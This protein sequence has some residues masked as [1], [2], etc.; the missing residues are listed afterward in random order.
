[1]HSST[2][3]S[4]VVGDDVQHG[5]CEEHPR[6]GPR[7]LVDDDVLETVAFEEQVVGPP[8]PLAHG[9]DVE[10]VGGAVEVDVGL[11]V[12]SRGSALL[13]VTSPVS[14][15]GRTRSTTTVV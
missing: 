15:T 7:V 9:N 2:S 4:P 5:L 12:Q 11:I 8:D 3:N 1:M 10:V 13:S 6:H 14:D